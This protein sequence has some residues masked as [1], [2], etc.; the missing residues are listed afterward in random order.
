LG[1]EAVKNMA[2]A[3]AYAGIVALMVAI[4][5]CGG[6]SGGGDLAMVPASSIC[7]L[8]VGGE[9]ADLLPTLMPED[10]SGLPS[11]LLRDLLDA[12]PVGISVI[13]VDF[14]DLRPQLML[15]SREV[16]E[17]RMLDLASSRLDCRTE[18]RADR[19]ELMTPEGSLLGAVASRDG[20]SC[21]YLGRATSAVVGP[22]LQME[23]SGSLAADTGLARLEGGDAD[24]S[25]MLPGNM[26]DFLGLLPLQRWYPELAELRT[27]FMSLGPRALRM[28][29]HLS[30]HPAVEARLLRRGGAVTRLRVE[31][32][33]SEISAD[34]IPGMLRSLGLGLQ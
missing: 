6:G 32:E 11:G 17:E 27:D 2:R 26:I 23:E 25:L 1:E 20:W 14:T 34:S 31:L 33:D 12:G 7:Y 24:L 30:P 4:A 28:D 16:S 9:A 29:L 13:S 19:A 5:G 3:A 15:L 18:Q 21:L 8:R 22:W 10:V